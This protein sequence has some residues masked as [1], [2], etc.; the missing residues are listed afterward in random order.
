[1]LLQRFSAIF[2][3]IIGIK[4]PVL[5]RANAAI[6]AVSVAPGKLYIRLSMKRSVWRAY[7]MSFH[8]EKDPG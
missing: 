5:K 6:W 7:F 8:V 1:M 2:S 3:N 4:M